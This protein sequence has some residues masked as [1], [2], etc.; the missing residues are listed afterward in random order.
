MP[1]IV[2][3]FLCL[4]FLGFSQAPSGIWTGTLTNDSLTIRKDQ[5]FEIALTTYRGKVYGYT[6]STFIVNDSLFYIIKRVKGQLNGSECVVQDEEIIAHNFQRK[7][8]KGVRVMYTF[9]QN[10]QDSTWVL[11]GKWKTNPTKKFYSIS[12]GLT[13]FQEKDF[14]RSRLMDHLADLNLQKSLVFDNQKNKEEEKIASYPEN[15]S[16]TDIPQ[17]PQRTNTNPHPAESNKNLTIQ[18]EKTD[19]VNSDKKAVIPAATDSLAGSQTPQLKKPAVIANKKADNQP[20]DTGYVYREIQIQERKLKP[21]AA[22]AAERISV[23]SETIYFTSDS[24]VL[25]LYDNGEVDGDTV[26]V[27]LNDEVII[28]KQV[29]KS[30]A[31]KKTIYLLPDES[32]SVLLVLFAENLGLY[33]PN[34]GLLVIQDGEKNIY[35]RF[36]ADFDQ[37]AAILLRRKRL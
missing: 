29:L 23:P 10:Q 9:H 26:S 15:K 35:V 7:P 27:I 16:R 21:L 5:V 28:E 31:Y 37:N 22:L 4:P 2:Y 14:S 19:I 36:K 8:D 25:A 24:L 17:K 20:Q 32:D 30:T 3:L 11:D 34:T 18:N 13:V 33:P 1:K 12:G 6:Y